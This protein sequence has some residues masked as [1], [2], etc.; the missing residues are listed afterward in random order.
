MG[1][2]GLSNNE[3]GNGRLEAVNGQFVFSRNSLITL[4]LRR[5]LTGMRIPLRRMRTVSSVPLAG[6]PP[7]MGQ[8]NDEPQ[9]VAKR[10]Q[11]D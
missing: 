3:S 7:A 4:A 11:P 5:L 9:S 8:A 10:H 1:G 2:N 6:V